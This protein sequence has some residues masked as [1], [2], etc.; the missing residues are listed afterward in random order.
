MQDPKVSVIVPF[1][2]EWPQ[3]AFTI[4][5]IHESLKGISHEVLAIDNL[6]STM[7]EDRG[8]K[9]LKGMANEWASHGDP[10]LKYYHVGDKLSHW[11]CKNFAMSK[12]SGD[13]FWFIDSH[14]IM[15][16]GAIEAI[17]YYVNN[18][19][20]LLGSMHMPLT[21]HIL[22][23]KQLMYKAAVEVPKSDYHYTFHTFSQRKYRGMEV[24]E[25]PAMSTCGMMIHKDYMEKLGHWP[26]ELGIYGGGENFINFTMAILGLKKWVWVG[27]SLCHHGDKRGY[28]W[29]HYD[30]QRNRGIATYMF[31]GERVLTNWMN[32]KARL[33]HASGRKA[34]RSILATCKEHR[35]KIKAS[36]VYEIEEWVNLWKDHE[37]MIGD[38]G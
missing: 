20:A 18:Y 15:P 12:A 10:W 8:S 33:T 30:Q 35:A 13:V 1:V 27:D 26:K 19:E 32:N 16:M 38:F 21:Y 34:R 37:L 24:V 7:T 9:N 5:S 23:P 25:V 2:R 28:A 6:T 4:R 22:E 31:G 3:V 14:C 11:Q 17:E 29:N 36:Q